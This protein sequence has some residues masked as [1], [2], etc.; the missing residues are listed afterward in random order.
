MHCVKSVRSIA[1]RFSD[2]C[3]VQSSSLVAFGYLWWPRITS[4]CL[5]IRKGTDSIWIRFSDLVWIRFDWIW[6]WFGFG[7]FGFGFGGIRFG[8]GW[9]DL[10]TIRFGFDSDSFGSQFDWDSIWNSVWNSVWDS[11]WD[12]GRHVEKWRFFE[13]RDFL[14][15]IAL[16]GLNMKF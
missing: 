15:F 11:V 16:R 14:N 5:C 2:A 9:D 8:F 13:I 1:F 10:D 12:S 3:H 4:G 7:R 6:L